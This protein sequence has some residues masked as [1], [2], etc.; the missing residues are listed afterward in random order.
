MGGRGSGTWYRFGKKSTTG[1]YLKLSMKFFSDSGVTYDSNYVPMSLPENE[2]ILP[3]TPAA[4]HLPVTYATRHGFT[5]ESSK[6]L[7]PPLRG[8]FPKFEES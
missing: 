8:E 3:T 6:P 5:T 7:Q 2:S 4:D 1:D